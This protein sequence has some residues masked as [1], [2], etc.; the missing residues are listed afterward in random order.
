MMLLCEAFA[1]DGEGR[2]AE[3]RRRGLRA[4]RVCGAA[5]H[6]V[7]C[8]SLA[9]LPLELLLCRAA[10]VQL[11]LLCQTLRISTAFTAINHEISV[12]ASVLPLAQAGR[13]NR[14]PRW[15]SKRKQPIGAAVRGFEQQS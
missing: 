9:A 13:G 1:S 6:R 2:V 4:V 7:D 14:P 12:F 3:A 11:R 10:G 5:A 8:V 15:S